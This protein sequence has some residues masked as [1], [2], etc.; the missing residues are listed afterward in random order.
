MFAES[1]CVCVCFV[2]AQDDVAGAPALDDCT[3]GA[4]AFCDDVCP[5]AL[6]ELVEEGFGW[7]SVFAATFAHQSRLN[8]S[9]S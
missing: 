4:E 6:L 5:G 3:V 1:Y 2:W 8:A 7:E 9:D